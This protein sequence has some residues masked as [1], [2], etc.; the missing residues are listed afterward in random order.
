MFAR[1]LFVLALAVSLLPAQR[2]GRGGNVNN[3]RNNDPFGNPNRGMNNPRGNQQ[4]REPRSL[5]RFDELAIRLGLD[6]DQK[7]AVRTLFDRASKEAEPVRQQMQ[8]NRKELYEAVK[9]G[10]SEEEISALVQKQAPLYAQMAALEMRAFAR[11]FK[12]LDPNQHKKAEEMMPRFAGF[13][14]SK[15][16]SSAE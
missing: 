15:K 13:F 3:P 14:Q 12:E 2:G 16:W 1:V 6:R 7:K 8:Q 4:P 10:K 9:G 11:M 5:S